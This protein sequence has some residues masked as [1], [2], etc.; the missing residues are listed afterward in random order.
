MPQGRRWPCIDLRRNTAACARARAAPAGRVRRHDRGVAEQATA[1]Q[2]NRS[3][4]RPRAS[5]RAPLHRPHI[6]PSVV[7]LPPLVTPGLLC[8]QCDSTRP[9]PT[10]AAH[11]S[12]PGMP[13]GCSYPALASR[14]CMHCRPG[15]VTD[16]GGVHAAKPKKKKKGPTS[17]G[18]TDV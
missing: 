4:P 11:L 8:R 17:R 12:P 5:A 16:G 2:R 15:K 10:L 3:T 14:R 7:P 18:H 13:Q 9:G 1:L 6:S